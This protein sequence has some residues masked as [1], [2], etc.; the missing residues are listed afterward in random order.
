[1]RI[2]EEY[3]TNPELVFKNFIS[4]AERFAEAPERRL[5]LSLSSRPE[6]RDARNEILHLTEELIERLREACTSQRAEPYRPAP[7]ESIRQTACWLSNV[8]ILQSL[9]FCSFL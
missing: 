9:V 1:R 7:A 4:E 2:Q 6:D 5:P 8:E 3:R